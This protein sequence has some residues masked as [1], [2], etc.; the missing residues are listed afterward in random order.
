M[1]FAAAD[2]TC[3][4]GNSDRLKEDIRDCV[5]M[6][7]T[8]LPPCVNE[9]AGHFTVCGEKAIRFGMVGV[10]SVGERTVE[11][12]L[13]AREAGGKFTSLQNFCDRVD[14][15]AINRQAAESL[16]KAGAFDSIPGNRAQK[17]VALEDALRSGARAQLDRRRGQK[18]LF[19]GDTGV[20]AVETPL[21]QIPEWPPLEMGRHEKEALGLR[22]SFNPL[23]RY[24]AVLSQL[25]TA[26]SASLRGLND[27]AAVYIGGEIIAIRPTITKGG[28]AMAHI[29]MEDLGGTIRGVVF[30]DC[31]EKHGGLLKEDAILFAVGTVDRSTERP[32]IKVQ[33]LIPI[34]DAP[35]RLTGAVK[36]SLQRTALNSKVVDDIKALCQRHRGD[37]AVLVEVIEPDQKRVLVKAGRDMAVRPA[38]AFIAG[39]S[40]LIGEGHVQL[41][42]RKPQAQSNGNGRARWNRGE[43][44]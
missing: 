40:R 8:V 14:S 20:R 11:A 36:L 32:G 4:M 5:R 13:R 28:H 25:A 24:E 7:I 6:G 34:A 44:G 15:A 21:P 1:E 29:E 39:M 27:G 9:G 31:F 37:C 17:V 26:T 19:G 41:I 30:P 22:L 12:V 3:E 43:N 35:A 10:K 23:D 38:E 2:L 33:E 42:P 18:S 16:I